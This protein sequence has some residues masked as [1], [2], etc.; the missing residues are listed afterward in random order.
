[1]DVVNFLLDSQ[2]DI[3]AV[4]TDGASA[5]YL[6]VLGKQ[7]FKNKKPKTKKKQKSKS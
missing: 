6:A 7:V 4:R 5:L 1:V 3:N 2:A